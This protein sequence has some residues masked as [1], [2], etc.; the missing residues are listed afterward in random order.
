MH[1][2][3]FLWCTLDIIGNKL[4]GTQ[5]DDKA[6]RI[7]DFE[8]RINCFSY[9]QLSFLFKILFILREAGNRVLL[10]SKCYSRFRRETIAAFAFS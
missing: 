5:I 4:L 6:I 1:P 8:L 3:F 2:N 10:S 7:F 9:L